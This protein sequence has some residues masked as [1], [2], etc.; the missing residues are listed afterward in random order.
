MCLYFEFV[1]LLFSDL[2]GSALLDARV[3]SLGHSALLGRK[4]VQIREP[5]IF[6]FNRFLHVRPIDLIPLVSLLINGFSMG[7]RATGACPTSIP[8]DCP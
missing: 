8:S 1:W 6:V 5:Q 4:E 2:P 3:R 7:L